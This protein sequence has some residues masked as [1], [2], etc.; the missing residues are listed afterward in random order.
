MKNINYQALQKHVV[1]RI[2]G[3][4]SQT[5]INNKLKFGYNQVSKWETGRTQMSW[6]DFINLCHACKKDI[7]F[8]LAAFFGYKKSPTNHRELV[9]HLL[10]NG[11]K[12]ENKAISRFKI[13][14][15]LNKESSPSWI[16]LFTLFYQ[17]YPVRSF[18]FLQKLGIDDLD[19]LPAQIIN[20]NDPEGFLFQHASFYF[21]LDEYQKHTTH[22]PG[23]LAKKMNIS[24]QEENDIIQGMLLVGTLEQQN[25]G[26]FYPKPA[27]YVFDQGESCTCYCRYL[28]NLGQ[29]LLQKFSKPL[30][31]KTQSNHFIIATST[32][33]FEKIEHLIIEAHEKTIRL[34]SEED[35]KGTP[36][37]GIRILNMQLFD[38]TLLTNDTIS[39][40]EDENPSM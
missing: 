10:E 40:R 18:Y 34:I 15:W 7:S 27:S 8:A 22:T 21:Y 1:K 32:S 37:D 35:K 33:V 6:N 19:L 11:Q 28:Q 25:G 13:Y 30:P 39:C 9:E 16:N 38:P 4:Y 17:L 2:R 26:K 31:P 36:I 3:K 20:S 29:Q 14:R 24:L 12:I 5:Q 23:F